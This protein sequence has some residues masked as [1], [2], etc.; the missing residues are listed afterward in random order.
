MSDP[1]GFSFEEQANDVYL[2]WLTREI[3]IDEY[4]EQMRRLRQRHCRPAADSAN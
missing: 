3:T 1:I 2:L 4:M